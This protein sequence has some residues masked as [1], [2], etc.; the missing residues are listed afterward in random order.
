[1]VMADKAD[2]AN[3]LIQMIQDTGAV[4]VIP[5]GSHRNQQRDSDC[6]GYKAPKLVEGFF[7]KIKQFG[8]IATGDEKLDCNFM[9][10]L[11]LVCTII[12]LA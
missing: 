3:D 12:C 2:E 5:V 11:N 7:N 9:S 6:H 8:R 1:M 4:V 10:M